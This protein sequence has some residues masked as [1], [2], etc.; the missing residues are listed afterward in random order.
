MI[1]DWKLDFVVDSKLSELPDLI[2]LKRI[3]LIALRCVDPEAKRRPKMGDVIHMLE[4]RDLLLI[5]VRTLVPEFDQY[6][7]LSAC[8]ILL[9]IDMVQIDQIEDQM[10]TQAYLDHLQENEDNSSNLSLQSSDT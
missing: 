8:F 7:F 2:E 1:S 10:Q 3:L 9:S 5:E 6:H 4:P